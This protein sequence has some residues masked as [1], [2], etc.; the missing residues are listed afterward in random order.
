MNEPQATFSTCFGAPFMTRHP[1]VYAKLLGEKIA[2]TKVNCWLVNTG[3]SGGPYGVGQRMKIAHTRAMVRAALDGSLA[4]VG[5]KADPVFGLHIPESCPNVPAEVLNPRNTWSDKA[6]YDST[7]QELAKRF[8][9]N[10]KQYEAHV[11]A[12]V[13]AAAIKPAA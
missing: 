6:A 12:K 1:S 8:A 4:G 13:M 3:W 11:D 5:T 10:F 7:A 9:A 2:G